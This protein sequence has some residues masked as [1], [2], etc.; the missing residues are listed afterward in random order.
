[1][2]STEAS[3]QSAR[4]S[5][6]NTRRRQRDSDSLQQQSQRKRSKISTDT[7][8]STT[9]THVNGDARAAINGFASYGDADRSLVL[10]DMPVRE[11]KDPAKRALKD[12]T[13]L[14]LVR[15]G[16]CLPLSIPSLLICWP[17]QTKTEHYSIKKLHSFPPTL[18]QGSSMFRITPT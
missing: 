13:A 11:K 16:L 5:L 10:V 4:G 17:P 3:V 12:D 8:H 18:S 9:D 7:Y 1:M 6:R 15:P 2:F 14:Y